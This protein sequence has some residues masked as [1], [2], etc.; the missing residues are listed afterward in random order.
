[1]VVRSL[2][3]IVK[4]LENN[5]Q[6]VGLLTERFTVTTTAQ[7]HFTTFPG[8]KLPALLANNSLLAHGPDNTPHPQRYRDGLRFRPYH[9][10]TVGL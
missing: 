1:V 5:A 7:K 2:R 6:I 10:T 8:D 9:K 3:Q 4:I